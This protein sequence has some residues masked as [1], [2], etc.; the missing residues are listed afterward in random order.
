MATISNMYDI[1]NREPY[2]F[3]IHKEACQRKIDKIV[4]NVGGDK[5][6]LNS[7]EKEL[8]K[9]YIIQLPCFLEARI[10]RVLNLGQQQL[11]I[12]QN[13]QLFFLVNFV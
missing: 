6:R 7:A 10:Q 2:T 9:A 11:L 13:N 4:V 1:L 5:R 8:V 3:H 12:S